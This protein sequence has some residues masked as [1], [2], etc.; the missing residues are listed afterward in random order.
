M[1]PEVFIV[2][3]PETGKTNYLGRCWIA[4]D[5][6]RSDLSLDGLPEEMEAL[7]SLAQSLLGG[8]YCAHT[9]RGSTTELKLD[10]SDRTSR[11]RI[12]ALTLPD[13]S[14][15]DCELIIT[16]RRWSPEW[17]RA[18][19]GATG[20]LVFI[21]GDKINPCMD[22]CEAQHLGVEPILDDRL[23]ELRYPSDVVLV[24]LLQMFAEA[25]NLQ[26]SRTAMRLGIVVSCWDALP[27]DEQR[28]FPAQYVCQNLKLLDQFL[29]ANRGTFSTKFFGLSSTGG[30]LNDKGYRNKYLANPRSSG[31][32]VQRLDDRAERTPDIT[33]PIN[34]VLSRTK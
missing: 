24:E 10:V 21:R 19:T 17:E 34:W 26:W 12:G 23:P 30:D 5:G 33:A 9:K 18:V 22:R 6:A 4:I 3:E 16:K 7:R 8:T 1:K 25:R 27:P 15:E 11:E 29:A 14:G 28:L 20:V 13:F 31:Y 2:G 32:V